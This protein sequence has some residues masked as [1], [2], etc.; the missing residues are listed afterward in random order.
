MRNVLTSEE[1]ALERV[2][3][4]ESIQLRKSMADSETKCES[5]AN[6]NECIILF[7]LA[8]EHARLYAMYGMMDLQPVFG[9][10][11]KKYFRVSEVTADIDHVLLACDLQKCSYKYA[12]YTRKEEGLKKT[13][14]E[15]ISRHR[16]LVQLPTSHRATAIS[17]VPLLASGGNAD[18]AAV[19]EWKDS[20]LSIVKIPGKEVGTNNNESISHASTNSQNKS[21][22]NTPDSKKGMCPGTKTE[23]SITPN[24][25]LLV[26]NSVDVWRS[27]KPTDDKFSGSHQTVTQKSITVRVEEN[28]VRVAKNPSN[29]SPQKGSKQRTLQRALMQD[30]WNTISCFCVPCISEKTRVTE[31]DTVISSL[32]GLQQDLAAIE[33]SNSS[34]LE[35]LLRNVSEERKRFELEKKKRVLDADIAAKYE[36]ELQRRIDAQKALEVQQ[37]EDDNAVCDICGDGES[38]G[39][40]RIIFCDSCDVSVHQHCYGVDNVPRGDYF[41]RACLYFKKDQPLASQQQD[42]PLSSQP[43]NSPQK[44][45]HALPPITCELCPKKQGAFVQTQT[46][47]KAGEKNPP[48]QWVHFLCAKWQGLSIVEGAVENG[49][50]VFMIENVQPLKDHFRSEETSCFLCKGMRGSYNKCRH[51]GCERWMHVTCARSSGY[52]E[53][54]H[55]DNHIGPVESEHVWTL[56][57]PEHSKFDDDY[58]P[59]T[60]KVSL[61]K[62]VALAETYPVEPK[63]IPP[64]APLKPF[65]KMSG[66]ERRKRLNDPEYEKEFVSL[67]MTKET[68]LRCEVCDGNSSVGYLQKCAKCSSVA[69]KECC[70]ENS[71]KLEQVTKD[72]H[73]Y[74][75]SS[76]IYMEENEGDEIKTG[77]DNK[78]ECHMCF[79]K[80]GTLIRCSAKPVTMKKWKQNMK[81]FKKSFFGKQIWCHPVCG[82]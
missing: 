75:C 64:S 45:T 52:C 9:P 41:C 43:E 3:H 36:A 31:G 68:G 35:K 22:M 44:R 11:L 30:N 58:S 26:N 79:S 40:N 82:M 62:L 33:R 1:V 5:F 21:E 74:I 77:N 49:V 12:L 70:S 6:T 24:S 66:K 38:T 46:L 73:Q 47:P 42:Q 32:K 78:L 16:L 37:E 81:Q 7:S 27:Q 59:P 13:A 53:V 48:N 63:P 76:C 67:L 4:I 65:Y 72:T 19:S 20:S 2:V 71:W 10:V 51:E 14:N 17:K 29:R 57:C 69:H 25:E 39:E 61:D 56:C 54:I 55:G 23:V 80:H 15:N 50:S 8:F 28:K 60:N 34:V 18:G